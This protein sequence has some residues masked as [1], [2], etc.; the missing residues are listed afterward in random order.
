LIQGGKWSFAGPAVLTYSEHNYPSTSSHWTAGYSESFAQAFAEWA[1]VANISFQRISGPADLTQTGADIALT[2]TAEVSLPEVQGL[3]VS[4]DPAVADLFLYAL[5]DSRS[6]YPR[7]EGDIF[8]NLATDFASNLQPGGLS[9][10]VALHEIGHALGLKHPFDDGGSGRPTFSQLGIGSYDKGLW[11]VMSLQNT[12]SSSTS[13]GHQATPMPLDIKAVQAIY[14]PNMSYHTGDDVYRLVLDG[15]LRTIWDAG[16]VDTLDASALTTGA[17]LTLAPGEF[18]KVQFGSNPVTAIAFDVTIEN[19]IGSNL[20]DSIAGNRVANRLEGG[21]GN[22]TM[23]G[24]PGNDVLDG[25]AGTLDGAV[26]SSGRSA[27]TVV[28]APD[29]GI[30]VGQDGGAGDGIDRLWNV[31]SLL[32]AGGT[33]ASSAADSP[34]EYVAS[35]DDLMT[36][37]GA[38]ATSGFNHYVSAGCY[39]GRKV[40]FDGLAYIA[41]YG[42]LMNALGANDEGGAAHYIV[43]GRFEGRAPSFDG[44]EYIA[45]Y[46]DLIDALGTN[47]DAG[48]SHYIQAGRFEGRTTSFDGLEY[49]ASY[50]DLIKVFHTEVAANPDPDIGANHY[51]AAGYAEHRAPDLF[52]AASYLAHYADLQAA[53]HGDLHAAT[54]HYITQGYFEGR[55]DHHLA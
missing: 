36:A 42:D 33:I 18:S 37:L 49:V 12:N 29:G 43:A 53:F 50:G 40:T 2:L 17:T 10:W 39:E 20:R 30:I 45:S 14:G 15:A 32:F 25:G 54:V 52:D 1:N 9:R 16:G 3:G 5:G 13:A 34:L 4:P 38:N 6:E 47:N 31:E 23:T 41:S 11:T 28:R 19:A 55:T 21:G 22:D 8:F 26:Y 7:P 27:Y 46:P 48:A 44:L 24:G 35:Y 51:I